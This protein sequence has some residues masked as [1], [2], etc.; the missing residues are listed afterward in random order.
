MQ[1]DPILAEQGIKPPGVAGAPREVGN[2]IWKLCKEL[3]PDVSK[4]QTMCARSFGT[5]RALVCVKSR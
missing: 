5:L 1:K 2:V 3:Y 4:L